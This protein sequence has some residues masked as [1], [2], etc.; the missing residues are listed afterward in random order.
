MD[1]YIAVFAP[2]QHEIKFL[3]KREEFALGIEN[4]DLNLSIELLDRPPHRARF[5]RATIAGDD[6][7]GFNQT[8]LNEGAGRTVRERS[9]G[10][11]RVGR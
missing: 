4:D 8:S 5:P 10:G 3:A 11:R 6:A 2:H 9:Y 1:W 7:S